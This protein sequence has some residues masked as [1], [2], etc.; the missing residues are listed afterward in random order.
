ML[1]LGTRE[2][3]AASFLRPE[4]ARLAGEGTLACEVVLFSI[5]GP[6]PESATLWLETIS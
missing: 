1:T 6:L 4:S 3:S 2:K 5:H